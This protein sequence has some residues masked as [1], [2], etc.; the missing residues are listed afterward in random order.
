MLPYSLT[1]CY[2]RKVNLGID[3]EIKSLHPYIPVPLK[4]TN[5]DIF[6]YKLNIVVRESLE[7]SVCV[8]NITHSTCI[9]LSFV[10]CS[11]KCQEKTE[12]GDLA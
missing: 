9:I 12:G 10:T 1:S 2:E 4:K 6:F 3:Q 8:R 5:I 7:L 11:T